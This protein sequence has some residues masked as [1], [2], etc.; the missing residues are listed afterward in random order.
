MTEDFSHLFPASR[1]IAAL[2]AD[3]RIRRIRA[4]RWINYPRAEQALAKLEALLAFPQRARMP[5]LL[6]VGASGMGKTMIVEKFARDHPSHF[7]AA[8]GRMHMPVIVVQM[9]PGPD[10]SRFYKRLLGT[11]GAPEPPRATL[12]V[13]ESLTLRLLSEIRPGL[14]IIDEVHSL[15]AGTVREQARFLN[16]LRFLGNELRTPLVC[17]GT[18]QARNALRTDDQLVRRFEAFALPPWQN[19]QDFAGL[20][21]SL[22]RTLPLRRP[23]EIADATLKRLVEVT[24]GITAA[25]FALMGGLAIAAIESGEERITLGAV[26]DKRNVLALLGEP[27]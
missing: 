20:I 7:D 13:L 17:V 3:E 10:E 21:G 22:Q 23:S 19:D 11:I 26:A 12:S 18:Q 15:H 27:V 4:D 16:M 2:S 1:A 24:G 8:T 25:V 14:L 6:I 9:V 5:N